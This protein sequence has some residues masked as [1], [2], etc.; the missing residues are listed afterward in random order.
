M[1]LCLCMR[2][3]GGVIGCLCDCFQMHE[4]VRVFQRLQSSVV[5]RDFFLDVI[6]DVTIEV[7]EHVM[8]DAICEVISGALL[9]CKL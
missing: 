6:S 7:T 4:V 8:C 9:G 5:I 1:G 3:I 2:V